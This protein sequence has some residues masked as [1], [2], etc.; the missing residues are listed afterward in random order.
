MKRVFILILFFLLLGAAARSE[1]LFHPYTRLAVG[2]C[3][4]GGQV[5]LGLTPRWAVELR[6]LTGASEGEAGERTD[7]F[8]GSLRVYRRL[9]GSGRWRFFSGGEGGYASADAQGK[10]GDSG[11]YIAGVFGGM[12]YY[13]LKRLSLGLDAGPYFISL[14]QNSGAVT[15]STVDIVLNSSIN[16]YFF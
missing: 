15:D 7:S 5:R 8:V 14:K 9:G 10:A 6:A 3:Y 4:A 11:G 16:F 2:A 13:P 12:E 1:E